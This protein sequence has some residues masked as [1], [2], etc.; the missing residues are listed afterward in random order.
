[1]PKAN[2]YQSLHTVLFGPY[3]VPIEVQIRTEDMHAVAESGIAAHW[4]YKTDGERGNAAEKHA[5]QWMRELLELHKEAGD[6]VEFI[7]HL[8]VDL[9]PDEIFVFTPAGDILELPHSATAVDLAYAFHTD[10]GNTCVAVKVDRNYVPLRTQ[11]LTGANRRGRYRTLGPS[12]TR[13]G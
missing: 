1:M 2:G 5:H 4:D 8:K 6:S 7:E 3:G 12:Q 10:V 9:F 13:T 11:L